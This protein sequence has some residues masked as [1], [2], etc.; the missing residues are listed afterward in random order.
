FEMGGAGGDD[1]GHGPEGE[2]RARVQGAVAELEVALRL[3]SG[4]ARNVEREELSVGVERVLESRLLR[5][6]LHRA[7][8][9][10]RHHHAELELRAAA[11]ARGAADPE[12]LPVGESV[13]P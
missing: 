11:D 9:G 12:I 5:A 7:E 2:A 13:H 4:E 6:V 3:R 1:R 10:A 8:V